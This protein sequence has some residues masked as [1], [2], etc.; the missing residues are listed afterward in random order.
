M[1]RLPVLL[2]VAALLAPAAL[3]ASYPDPAKAPRYYDS[4]CFGQFDRRFVH[5]YVGV[6]ALDHGEGIE[7][8][9]CEVYA[10]THAHFVLV[11]VHDTG[12][13]PLE[14]Y[15]LH[16]F[17]TWGVGQDEVHDGLM[18]LYVEDYRISGKASALRV[19]VGY[20]LEGAV[21]AGVAN[22]AIR[23]MQDA[24]QRALD[25]GRS[26]QEA[27]SFA[28]ATGSAYLLAT[29]DETYVDGSFPE[30][31]ASAQVPPWWFWLVVVGGIV[32]LVA[33]FSTTAP[34]RRGRPGWGY[35]AGSAAW[36]SGLGGAFGGS[37]GFGG[38]GSFGGGR[39][40]GGG[41]SGGF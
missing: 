3:A 30:P 15:A 33:I 26:E 9:A 31:D 37:G 8:A 7:G 20:G 39:S 25:A 21:N 24:K 14:S 13:E 22:D 38:G 2:L 19:E 27:R 5:D 16:L 29:L 41:G 1:R 23:L 11:A 35:Y 17:E 36:G 4:G 12:G 18:L 28:L 32:L 34:P 6:M 10:K 40:G